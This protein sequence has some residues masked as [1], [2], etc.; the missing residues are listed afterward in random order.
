MPI[1]KPRKNEKKDKFISRCMSF[2]SDEKKFTQEQ[3]IAI[4]NAQFSRKAK[5]ELKF[6]DCE[7]EEIEKVIEKIKDDEQ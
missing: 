5:G 1:P 2:L 4:C 7:L 6:A 3:R